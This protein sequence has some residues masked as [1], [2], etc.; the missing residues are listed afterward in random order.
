MNRRDYLGALATLLGVPLAGCHSEI[1]MTEDEAQ[2]QFD[3]VQEFENFGDYDQ[4]V[5]AIDEEAGVVIYAVSRRS[6]HAG[7][8]MGMTSVPLEDTTLGESDDD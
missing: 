3:D 5:R 2:Q 8:G 7:K 1:H 4:A 6:S